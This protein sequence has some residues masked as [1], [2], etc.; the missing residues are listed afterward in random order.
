MTTE[1]EIKRKMMASLQNQNEAMQ[2][3]M[4]QK[5]M[6]DALKNVMR[7]VLTPEARERLATL[8]S[9]K[10]DVATGLEI[11]LAQL[12]QSGQI[13]GKITEDQLVMILKKV[14]ESREIRIRRK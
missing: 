6:E 3:Q 5:Q 8:R 13:R 12:Y 11:Y 4:Q 7:N 1:E 2:N 9:V 14:N 10:P